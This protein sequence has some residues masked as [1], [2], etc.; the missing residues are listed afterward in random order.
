[1]KV[2]CS[3]EFLLSPLEAETLDEMLGELNSFFNTS[4]QAMRLLAASPREGSKRLS[5]ESTQSQDQTCT[6]NFRRQTTSLH[7]AT[8]TLTHANLELTPHTESFTYASQTVQNENEQT[9]VSSIDGV[10]QQI[11][12]CRTEEECYDLFLKVKKARISQISKLVED[13]DKEGQ[14]VL[15]RVTQSIQRL[16]ESSSNLTAR[17]NLLSEEIEDLIAS[18]QDELATIE[19]RFSL[20]PKV[21]LGYG[22]VSLWLA[23]QH[24]SDVWLL[25]LRLLPLRKTKNRKEMA[26]AVIRGLQGLSRCKGSDESSL[27]ISNRKIKL[28]ADSVGGTSLEDESCSPEICCDANGPTAYVS[29]AVPKAKMEQSNER[30]PAVIMKHDDESSDSFEAAKPIDAVSVHVD[31]FKKVESVLILTWA[32]IDLTCAKIK[33]QVLKISPFVSN[34]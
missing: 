30:S 25:A 26:E 8:N 2:S 20:A 32:S 16:T 24:T 23:T 18:S 19:R 1:M 27:C 11:S 9:I 34:C 15:N 3:K 10:E 4:S 12:T 31:R 14:M 17:Y 22:E 29:T 28:G 7:Q 13:F 5:S 6:P 33:R 21:I